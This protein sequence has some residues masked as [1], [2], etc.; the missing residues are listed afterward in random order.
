MEQM[1]REI[2]KSMKIKQKDIEKMTRE[3][4]KS[5]PTQKQMEKMTR[6]IAKSAADPGT[7]RANAA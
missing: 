6:D 7:D 3:I 5:V 2:E 4:E 1:R